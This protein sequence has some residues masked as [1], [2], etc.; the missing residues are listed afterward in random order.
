MEFLMNERWPP[1]YDYEQ[2]IT[3]IKDLI[4]NDRLISQ[5]FELEIEK[6]FY[7]GDILYL[8]APFAYL[9]QDAQAE[10]IDENSG[11]WLLLSNTCDLDRKLD[12]VPWAQIVPIE[13]FAD[14][15]KEE[16]EK[17]KNYQLSR[18]F[19]IPE[20]SGDVTGQ[21]GIADF[22]RPVTISREALAAHAKVVARLTRYSWILLHSCLVRYLARDDGRCDP[23]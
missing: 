20:W 9:N 7:Q 16:I 5:F 2:L 17:Y 1:I 19:Y 12:E 10:A 8:Q 23:G 3:T 21:H 6:T 13:L 14:L 15:T 22:C 18:A 11:Y 4:K